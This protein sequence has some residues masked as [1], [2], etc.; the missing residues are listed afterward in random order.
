MG[1]ANS[2]GSF[3]ERKN[4]AIAREKDIDET[5]KRIKQHDV[6][7]PAFIKFEIV[8]SPDKTQIAVRI[9]DTKHKCV[10]DQ[11]IF[12]YDMY[13]KDK[14]QRCVNVFRTALRVNYV[15]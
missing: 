3:E 11:M 2:R 4:K 7:P 8:V 13:K 14:G 15:I 9:T 6:V 1:E 10:L 5:I 12:P